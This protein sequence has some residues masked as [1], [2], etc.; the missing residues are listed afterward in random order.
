MTEGH[1]PFIVS[2][3]TYTIDTQQ[4]TWGP[5]IRIW[6][7]DKQ[8]GTVCAKVRDFYPYFYFEHHG[9]FDRREFENLLVQKLDKPNQRPPDGVYIKD[10]RIVEKTTLMGYQPNGKAPVFKMTMSAPTQISTARSIIESKGYVT[11]EANLLYILRFMVDK[12]FGGCHWIE[13]VD[14]TKCYD[15]KTTAKHEFFAKADSIKVH[16]ED[17]DLGKIRRLSFDIE[18]CKLDGKGFVSP[19]EDPITQIACCVDDTSGA[20]IDNVVF[21]LVPK[22]KGVTTPLPEPKVRVKTFESE[23][24]L[25]AA[26]SSYI[27]TQDID[28]ITGYNIDGFDFKYIFDRAKSLALEEEF[29]QFTRELGRKATLKSTFF[30]SAA[31]GTREDY[32]LVCEGRFAMDTMKFVK[33]FM[34]FRSYS[35]AN[36][37]KELLGDTKVDMPYKLIPEYQAGTDEQRAHLAYYC[38]KDAK[39]CFD[40]LEKRKASIMY[41]Q[42]AR[43]CGVPMKFLVQRGQQILTRS[44]LGRYCNKHDFIVPSSTESQND[45][46]TK[47]ATVWEPKKGF[48]TRPI[49]TLDFRSLYPSCIRNWNICYSTKVSLKW[50]QKNLGQGDYYVPPM[51]GVTY[52]FVAHHIREGILPEIEETLHNFRNWAKG[53]M[54]KN[55]GTDLEVVYDKLQEAVKLRMNSLY[56]FLKANMVCDKD[57]MESV[58]GW[59]RWMLQE[60]AK[61]VEAKF[62][63]SQIVYGDTDSVFVDF[64]N[65]SL[66]RAFELGQQAADACT[67]LF[68]KTGKGGVHLL[69]REKA[70]EPFLLCGKK[71][72]AGRK[73][74][75]PGE[76]FKMSSSGM[77]TVRRDNAKIASNTLAHCLDEMIMKGDYTG[78]RAAAHVRETVNKLKRGRIDMSELIISKS[79]SK[80]ARH[81]AESDVKQVHS[82]LARRISERSDNTGEECYHTGDRVKFVMVKGIKNSKAF[83]RSEDPLYALKNRIPVDEDYYVE[84]QMMRPLLRVFTPVVAPHEDAKRKKQDREDNSKML[85]LKDLSSAGEDMKKINKNGDIVYLNDKETKQLTAYKLLFTGDHMRHT[86]QKTPKSG[87]GILRF[88][89]KQKRCPTCACVYTTIGPTCEGCKDSRSA[90]KVQLEQQMESLE[91]IRLS[92]LET[93]R[94]CVKDPMAMHV[95]CSNKDCDNFFKREK[96]AVD[97]EDLADKFV[98]F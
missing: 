71:K 13:F 37:S 51:P 78:E 67:E 24:K 50:A 89:K 18:A 34:K 83:E 31:T 28:I 45:E 35:L 58:T 72:Y 53:M 15:K 56:G 66:D 81:Y 2:D 84:N 27:I 70:F 55:K 54:K 7:R 75:G 22:G 74:L 9:S 59:G 40:I 94:A 33:T 87:S 52:C 64:G 8:G 1:L 3:V 68:D 25:L 39:L 77:E 98:G 69:Q 41:I 80:S 29:Y 21:C 95:P 79:L 38:W 57:L 49:V 48:Y 43:V 60:T 65:V 46:D 10:L 88:V 62:E 61:L 76:P 5:E 97:I 30:A 20:E 19:E 93:C 91:S 14:M 47:G 44:L 4:V 12:D 16:R 23:R 6:G 36:V 73:T 85:G 42:N 90:L 32:E 82:E 92:C 96:V 86:I 63:G 11:Y 17:N 26:F